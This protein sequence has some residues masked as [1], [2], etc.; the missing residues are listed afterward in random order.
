MENI[1]EFLLEDSKKYMNMI[2]GK[3]VIYSPYVFSDLKYDTEDELIKHMTNEWNRCKQCITNVS[4]FRSPYP[5]MKFE[6]SH[7]EPDVDMSIEYV[8]YLNDGLNQLEKNNISNIDALDTIYLK[9]VE[10]I[11]KIH[12]HNFKMIVY[13]SFIEMIMWNSEMDE[14][15]LMS[16]NRVNYYKLH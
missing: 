14:I 16:N 15:K 5:D 2:D 1:K 4:K 6:W 9:F 12:M 10:L 11:K 8:N 7:F 13:T 3:M